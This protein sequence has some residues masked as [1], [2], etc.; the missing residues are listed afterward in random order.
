M[1]SRNPETPAGYERAGVLLYNDTYDRLSKRLS[2]ISRS[3]SSISQEAPSEE[4]GEP[5]MEYPGVFRLTLMVIS[6]SLVSF[7]VSLDRTIVATAMYLF[8]LVIINFASPVISNY[9]ER[10]T[11]ESWYGSAYL[12]TATALQP[13]WGKVYQVFNVKAVFFLNMFLFL[14]GSLLSGAAPSSVLFII[15]RALAGMGA[16]GV[17]SGN[18]TMIA[19]SVPLHRRPAFTGG[20]GALAGVHLTIEA[21]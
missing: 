9:F 7:L 20:L 10:F 11:D 13:T 17:F 3:A 21:N 2:R 19:Y 12:L 16:G 5:N 18:L 4:S 14:T 6:M 15:G 8:L 1:S